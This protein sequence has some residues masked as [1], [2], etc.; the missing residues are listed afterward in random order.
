MKIDDFINYAKEKYQYYCDVLILKNGDV[1]DVKFGHTNTLIKLSG[2]SENEIWSEMPLS[3][4]PLAW[5]VDYTNIVA[6]DYEVILI[7]EITTIEQNNTIL[8]LYKNKLIAKKC[9]VL[10]LLE[11]KRLDME[12][13]YIETGEHDYIDELPRP[14][15]YNSI[16]DFENNIIK[17]EK[18]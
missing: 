15:Q 11:K 17:K 13:K 2:K 14:K 16:K 5:L 4:G 9:K 18:L 10:Q 3:A 7:P 12:K 6:V 1:V 8:K